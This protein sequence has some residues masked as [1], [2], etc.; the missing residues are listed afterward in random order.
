MRPSQVERTSN[1]STRHQATE[2]ARADA[3]H[4]APMNVSIS[5]DESWEP[6]RPS[7]RSNDVSPKPAGL[8]GRVGMRHHCKL[9]Q[10]FNDVTS[11]SHLADSRSGSQVMPATKRDKALSGGTTAPPSLV[12]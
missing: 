7:A 11:R 8:S 1:K 2:R 5:L 6:A 4:A 12:T 3:N 10:V 9:V